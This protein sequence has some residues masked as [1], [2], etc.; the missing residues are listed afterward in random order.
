[1]KNNSAKT[2]MLV[3]AVAIRNCKRN[4]GLIADAILA[5]NRL[6]TSYHNL[7]VVACNRELTA[8]ERRRQQSLAMGIRS[9]CRLI[10]ATPVIGGD[11]RGSV[12]KLQF[13]DD[14]RGNDFGAE[15]WCFPL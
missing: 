5:I 14:T 9:E 1:M 8:T 12:V 3:H 15:G 7:C 4:P 11:P 10:N 6:A 2:A 13:P